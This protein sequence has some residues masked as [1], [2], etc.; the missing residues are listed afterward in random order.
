MEDVKQQIEELLRE[1]EQILQED[2]AS[3]LRKALEENVS[4]VASL[5]EELR[6]LREEHAVTREALEKALERI[7]AI[8]KAFAVRKS[9]P[10]EDEVKVETQKASGFD[11]AL[12]A[13]LEETRRQGRSQMI[14]R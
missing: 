11:G 4:K 12:R 2:T 1:A 8:E 6:Q 10:A 13:L 7:E 14:L 3:D 5:E 9:A